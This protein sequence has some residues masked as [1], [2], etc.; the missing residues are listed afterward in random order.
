MRKSYTIVLEISPTAPLTHG[1]GT[2]GNEQ[3]LAT[4]EMLVPDGHG[5]M[6]R[7]EIPFV[8]GAALKA[9]LREHAVRDAMERAGVVEGSVS[10]DALRLLLKGGKNDSGGASVSIEEARRL[11]DLFPLLA[12]FGSMDGGLPIRAQVSCSHVLPYCAEAVAAGAVPTKIRP[13][14]VWLEG[15]PTGDGA[16]EIAVWPGLNP[17]PAAMCRTTTQNYR[18]DLLGS[19][20]A[21]MIATAETAAIEDKRGAL[22]AAKAPKKEARREANESMPHSAQAIAAGTPM[23]ATIRL[24]G[25]TEV[26]FATLAV[27]I[28]RWVAS[29][30]HLGGGATKGHGACRVRIAGAI[31]YAPP[32]GEAPAEPGTAIDVLTNGQ[33]HPLAAL[34]SAH[35][36]ERAEQIRAYCAESTR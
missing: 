6:E 27:A 5:G 8:S 31:R 10:R 2:E 18:H 9:T 14:E 32:A 11:R 17:I 29:G 19:A 24:Q 33:Q 1:S 35:V 3:I 12:V 30:G 16:A 28:S 4:C 26:E 25:A 15:S 36:R 13:L 22:F 20:L 21:P 23:V 7:E 34:Y